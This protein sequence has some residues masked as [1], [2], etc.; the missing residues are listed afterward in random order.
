MHDSGLFLACTYKTVTSLI[1]AFVKTLL[2]YDGLAF[3]LLSNNC[4][5][6]TLFTD[7]SRSI[8]KKCI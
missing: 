5:V 1:E 6:L 3:R 4:F 7:L 2:E 8:L